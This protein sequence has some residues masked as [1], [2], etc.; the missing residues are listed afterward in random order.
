MLVIES[1]PVGFLFKKTIW[2]GMPERKIC[3]T[4]FKRRGVHRFFCYLRQIL[5]DTAMCKGSFFKRNFQRGSGSCAAEK[6]QRDCDPGKK[7]TTMFLQC[8]SGSFLK[9][10]P[11]KLSEKVYYKCY[12]FNK[13][14]VTAI[15]GHG[16]SPSYFPISSG[17]F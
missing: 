5:K 7:N 10:C 16:T 15:E 9:L 2:R 12:C 14:G 11:A 8:H 1:K 4:L 17:L 13:S 6:Q 3:I